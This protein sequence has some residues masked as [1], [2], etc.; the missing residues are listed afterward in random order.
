MKSRRAIASVIGLLLVTGTTPATLGSDT[1]GALLAQLA[2]KAGC[3][4]AKAGLAVGVA[5]W[6]EDCGSVNPKAAPEVAARSAIAPRAQQLGL[7]AD[8]RDL[9]LLKVDRTDKVDYVRFQQMHEGVPV[10]A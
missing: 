10:F 2:D 7:R 6:L 3:A 9:T 5:R 4:S 8:G 1:S